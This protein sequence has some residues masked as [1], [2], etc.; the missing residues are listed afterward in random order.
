VVGNHG[1]EPGE[2]LEDFEKA[3]RIVRAGLAKAL[4]RTPGI[5]LEDKR[6]SLSVHFLGAEDRSAARRQIFDA[7]AALSEPVRVIDGKNVVNVLPPAAP[8]KGEALLRIRDLA[9]TKAALFVGDDV[10]DEDVFDLGR[11]AGLLTVRVG[12][13]AESAAAYFVRNRAE[14]DELLAWL[15]E[16][17][18][19]PTS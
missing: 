16:G 8:H 2:Q 11:Q 18:G 12:E 4:A 13:S 14:V 15:A 7:I 9:R 10:T 6:Y 3:M 1:M 17:R 19:A 5:D